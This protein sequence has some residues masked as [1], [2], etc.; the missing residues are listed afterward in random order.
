MAVGS[1][2][3][4]QTG[5]GERNVRLLPNHLPKTGTNDFRPDSQSPTVGQGLCIT[6]GVT[7]G[8]ST[9]ARMRMVSW[10]AAMQPGGISIPIRDTAV[11]QEL[12]R[13][14]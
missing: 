10:G 2:L 7:T 13:G 1:N 9:Q 6:L 8:P 3:R 11:G 14:G 5:Q 4:C 12:T